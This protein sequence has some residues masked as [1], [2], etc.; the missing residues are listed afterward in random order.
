[1]SFTFTVNIIFFSSCASTSIVFPAINSAISNAVSEPSLFTIF[2]VPSIYVVPSGA[3]S[4]TFTSAFASP[5]FVTVMIYVISSSF[6]TVVLLGSSPAFAATAFLVLH[7][8][9]VLRLLLFFVDFLS[10]V[11]LNF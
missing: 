7:H 2:A 1:M 5:S 8:L 4:C 9:L 3:L 6:S 10:L 11:L